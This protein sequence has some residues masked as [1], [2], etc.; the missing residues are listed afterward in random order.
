MVRYFLTNKAI[1]DLEEIWDYTFDNWSENQADYYY[2]LLVG[3]FVEIALNP[4]IGR[5]YPGLVDNLKGYLVGKH[6]VFYRETNT[7]NIEI[8]RI[9]HERMDLKNRI[10]EK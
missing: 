9:L 1:N 5:L 10:T 2:H 3:S 8:I 4:Q 6:I 7:E